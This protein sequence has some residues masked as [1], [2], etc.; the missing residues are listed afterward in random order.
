MLGASKIQVI[1][2]LEVFDDVRTSQVFIEDLRR[3]K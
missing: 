3:E 2:L 1:E